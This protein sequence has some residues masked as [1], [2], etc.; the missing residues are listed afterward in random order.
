M[1][2]EDKRTVSPRGNEDDAAI[3]LGSW[4]CWAGEGCYRMQHILGVP[5]PSA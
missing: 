2:A 3:P 1:S 4:R 5:L